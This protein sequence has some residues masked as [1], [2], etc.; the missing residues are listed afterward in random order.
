MPKSTSLLDYYQGLEY[1]KLL[2]S[3][4]L[5]L[6][7]DCWQGLVLEHHDASPWEIPEYSASHHHIGVMLGQWWGEQ[8]IDG[9]RRSVIAPI[10]SLCIIP[11]GV[12]FAARWWSQSQAIVLAVDPSSLRRVAY[13][14]VDC[15]HAELNFCWLHDGDPFIN[16]ISYLLKADAESG[17]PIG[18]LY[19]DSLATALMV[20]LLK[21]YVKPSPVFPAYTGKMP[22]YKMSRVLDYI[23]AHLQDPI[24]LKDLAD[25]AG[26]SQ[27]YF[28]RMFRQTMGIAPFEYVRQ[29]RIEKAKKLLEQTNLSIL[30]VGMQCG[31]TSPS[32]FSRQ[33][34]HT[35]GVTPKAY[36]NVFLL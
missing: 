15:D 20:H 4:P 3:P 6:S 33:F 19:G 12:P 17:Y 5:L 21:Q 1:D 7:Q 24:C 23:T 25:I 35:A 13:E 11:T 36:R 27:Y 34:R 18:S 14:A 2:P 16:Q 9:R 31:F 30:E 28:C 29:Q 26:M 32:H 10:G 8:W 22:K